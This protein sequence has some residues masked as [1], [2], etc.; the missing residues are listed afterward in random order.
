MRIACASNTKELIKKKF[1]KDDI[2]E[3]DFLY[4]FDQYHLLRFTWDT[5]E[6]FDIL[7]LDPEKFRSD[8]SSVLFESKKFCKI[9]F[10]IDDGFVENDYRELLVDHHFKKVRQVEELVR[11]FCYST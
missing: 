2:V 4:D 9:I 7:T 3:I 11:G 1:T 8:L 6:K 10:L 5:D